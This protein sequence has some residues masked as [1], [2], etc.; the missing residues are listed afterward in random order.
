MYSQYRYEGGIISYKWWCQI[1]SP[2]TRQ[3]CFYLQNFK[4]YFPN[5]LK[6][7]MRKDKFYDTSKTSVQV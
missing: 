7:V 4:S 6:R 1:Y 2:Y 5:D 3:L